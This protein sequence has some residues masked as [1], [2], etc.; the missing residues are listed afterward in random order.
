[1]Y[2]VGFALRPGYGMAVDD[3]RVAQ[4]WRLFQGKKVLHAG[5]MCQVEWFILWR[6]IAGGLAAGQQRAIA[7]PLLAAIRA[8]TGKG[9][10]AKTRG[11]EV[12][13]GPHELAEV[14]R[15]LASLELL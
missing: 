12:L 1:L 8:P 4:T 5:P 7:E 11:A 14:W 13:F 3:W 15:L 2:L 9:G 6:R 10:R